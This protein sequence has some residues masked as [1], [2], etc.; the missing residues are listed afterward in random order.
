MFR[1]VLISTNLPGFLGRQASISAPEATDAKKNKV[2]AVKGVSH[3]G[4]GWTA[5]NTKVREHTIS[6]RRGNTRTPQKSR[7][8]VDLW[9]QAQGEVSRGGARGG[10]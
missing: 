10:S 8:L 9:D 4:K 2:L 1:V 5:G 3:K 7:L 6:I